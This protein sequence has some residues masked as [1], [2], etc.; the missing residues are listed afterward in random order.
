MNTPLLLLGG[1]DI[2]SEFFYNTPRSMYAQLPD[3][4]RDIKEKNYVELAISKGQPIVGVCR[5]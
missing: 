5:G 4:V 2:G 1:T 3:V